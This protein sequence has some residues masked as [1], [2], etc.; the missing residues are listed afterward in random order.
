MAIKDQAGDIDFIAAFAP[1]AEFGTAIA[2]YL[3]LDRNL[4]TWTSER[5]LWLEA[6]SKNLE[7][8]SQRNSE[9]S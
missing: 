9:W 8:C 2:A 7:W 4:W 5:T 6:S 3:S 1:V